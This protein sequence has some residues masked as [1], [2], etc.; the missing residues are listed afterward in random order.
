MMINEIN[1][2]LKRF[3]T[4][5]KLTDAAKDYIVSVGYDAKYGAR[6]L[7]RAIQ[8]NIENR[9]A[10]MLLKQEKLNDKIISVDYSDN[11]TFNLI[12]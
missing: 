11:L 1:I 9:I 3:K 4:S 2:E 8:K 5:L 10:E 12:D 6:P 7:R